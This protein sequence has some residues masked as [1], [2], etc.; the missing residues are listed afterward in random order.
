MVFLLLL[1]RVRWVAVEQHRGGTYIVSSLAGG[2]H[3]RLPP[4]GG[5]HGLEAFANFFVQVHLLFEVTHQGAAREFGLSVHRQ[6][7]RL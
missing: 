3:K 1:L 5:M 6:L 2:T 4:Q 7:R